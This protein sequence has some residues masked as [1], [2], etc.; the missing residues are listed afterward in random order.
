MLSPGEFSVGCIGDATNSLTLVMPRG[1]YEYPMLVT[2]ASGSPYAIFLAG[3]F[4]YTGFECTNNDS[5]KGILIPNVT[6]EIDEESV[7]DAEY[8]HAP[9]GA[10]VRRDMQL[11][12]ITQAD[13]GFPRLLKT[14]LIVG[15]PACRQSS[16]AGFTKWRGFLG[17]G[18]TKRELTRVEISSKQLG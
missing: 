9:I 8:L 12:I 11:D 5:H 18:M 6:I 7:F 15:L 17:E 4:Q 14:P 10:L 2:Q 16:V 3:Q 1:G 13:G